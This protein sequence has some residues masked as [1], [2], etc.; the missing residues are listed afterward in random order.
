MAK[1]GQPR[2]Q[3]GAHFIDA[4]LQELGHREDPRRGHSEVA[5]KPGKPCRIDLGLRDA[6]HVFIGHAQRQLPRCGGEQSPTGRRLVVGLADRGQPVKV[7]PTIDFQ[8]T[9]PRSG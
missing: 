8:V 9:A 6:D 4:G 1:R 5:G 2:R 3:D 7:E